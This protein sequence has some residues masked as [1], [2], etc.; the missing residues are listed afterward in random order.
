MS[1]FAITLEENIKKKLDNNEFEQLFV[2]LLGWD[3][4]QGFQDSIPTEE[5]SDINSCKLLVQKRGVCL[6]A[7]NGLSV[8]KKLKAK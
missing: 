8:S 6:W 7:I 5:F 4:P 3:S 2:E 1:S